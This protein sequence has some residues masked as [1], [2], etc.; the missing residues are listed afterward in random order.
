MTMDP[1]HLPARR[2]A[3]PRQHGDPR[4]RRTL[5]LRIL[6]P[7]LSILVVGC[8]AGAGD[9]TDAATPSRPQADA[10]AAEASRHEGPSTA[11]PTAE[12]APPSA[13]A[14]DGL[15]NDRTT[16]PQTTPDSTPKII[17]ADA[18]NPLSADEARVILRK[19]T[20]RA[21]TGEYTDLKDAGTYV[22]RQCNL[23]LYRSDDKFSSHCGW[24]SFD[25]EL[26]NAVRREVDADGRRVE[27]LCANCDGHLGHV[28][29]G[30]RF[31]DKNVRHCV[32]SISMRFVPAGE[33]LPPT[34]RVVE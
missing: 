24:P 14:P 5:G 33:A 9:G 15:A 25:D 23:P 19:G 6:F 1:N 27:I 11:A 3:G 22:C 32:N 20:E 8:T 18:Y 7:T 2:E 13:S 31:T 28:F 10:G 4:L 34:L 12:D 16:T 29:E 30:E 17:M 26:P 21:F